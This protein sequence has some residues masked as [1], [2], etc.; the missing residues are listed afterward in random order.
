MEFDLRTVDSA[1]YFLLDFMQM[2]SED[3]I[4]DMAVNC[5]NNFETFWKNHFIFISNRDI[6]GLKFIGFH[7]TGSLDECQD[8]K[9]NGIRNLQLVLSEDNI[10]TKMLAKHG[11]Q[12]DISARTVQCGRNAY[13]LD[14]VPKWQIDDIDDKANAISLIAHRVYYDFCVNGFFMNDNIYAYGTNIHERPEFLM[15]L[16]KIFP[17]ADDL[18]DYW[19][20]NSESFKIDFYATLDQLH[21]FNFELDEHVDIPFDDWMDLN[22]DMR[23]KKWI[24][25]KAVARAQNELFSEVYLYVKDDISIPPEQIIACTKICKNTE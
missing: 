24:L 21:R 20:C 6:T 8:I 16:S 23:L 7:I 5:E 19:S 22:D 25:S 4:M 12:F 3:Y 2:K 1:Y 18:E 13:R 15:H 9:R 17:E 10:I 11:I 14:H